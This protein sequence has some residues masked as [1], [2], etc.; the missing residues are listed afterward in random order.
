MAD[1]ADRLTSAF[2][3][4]TNPSSRGDGRP[5]WVVV[6]L[7]GSYPDQDQL[8]WRAMLGATESLQQLGTKLT[9]IAESDHLTHVLV[10]VGAISVGL[11]T[12]D[13]IAGMLARLAESKKVVAMLPTITAGTLLLTRHVP[14]IIA[15]PSA[16]VLVSGMAVEQTYYGAFLRRHGIDFET[17]RIGAYKSALTSLTDE[18][19]DD[20]QREQLQAY[21]DSAQG[22][23]VAALAEARLLEPEAVRAW[24]SAD[25]VNA[26]DAQ[27]AGAVTRV[28][29]EDEVVRIDPKARMG[30][31]DLVVPTMA[32]ATAR[33][34]TWRPD[35]LPARVALVRVEGGIISGRSRPATPLSG[36]MVGSDTLIEQLRAAKADEHT[37]AIVLAVESGG[38]SALASDLISR[39]IATATVPVVAVMGN[40]AASG[41]YYVAARATEILASPFTLTGSIGVVMGR[42][43]LRELM[44][45]HG[46][47]AERLGD[48]RTL[49]FSPAKEMTEE[50][51]AWA[52]AM[53][54]DVYARFVDEVAQGR[55]RSHEEIDALGQGRIWSGADA[56][57]RGLIDALG[58]Q[59]D[60]IRRA[61]ELAGIA[62][63]APVWRPR[64]PR[65]PL[66]MVPE[67]GHSPASWLDPFGN[68]RVLTALGTGLPGTGITVRH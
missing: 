6:D 57:E 32:E 47:H 10:R 38:G 22:R 12:S 29:Y 44:E 3:C 63:D 46:I 37:K 49:A 45:R 21:L 40:V 24:L 43:V 58:T 52:R 30:A 14:E 67:V 11:A 20:A 60:A 65:A 7:H 18:Q 33:A 4:L 27:R 66:S 36:P 39:E 25:M 1:L 56:L 8:G 9:R 53:M 31:L 15:P 41:G 19:M 28:A 68:E 55:G 17:E 42:P 23:W 48:E 50:D 2:R 61:R 5:E 26:E 59:R 35:S 34:R 51:R 54:Q 16:D 62:E 64:T 13:A